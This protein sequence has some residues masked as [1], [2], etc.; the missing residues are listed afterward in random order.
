M[1]GE[2]RTK[3]SRPIFIFQTIMQ[4][5]TIKNEQKEVARVLYIGKS[6]FFKK[7]SSNFA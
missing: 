3:F 4:S 2:R 6:L 7:R 1:Q 5:S